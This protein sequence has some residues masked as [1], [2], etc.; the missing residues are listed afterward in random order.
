MTYVTRRKSKATGRGRLTSK[1]LHQRSTTSQGS[2]DAAMWNAYKLQC[3]TSGT[4]AIAKGYEEWVQSETRSETI[5]NAKDKRQQNRCE[6]YNLSTGADSS[7][8]AP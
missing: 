8:E 1:D 5:A 2:K 3:E 4:T 6:Q 7:D